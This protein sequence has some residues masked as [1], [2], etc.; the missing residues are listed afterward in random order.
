MALDRDGISTAIAEL[1]RDDSILF[2]PSGFLQ[3]IEGD[4]KKFSNAKVDAKRNRFALY[5][6][7][8]GQDSI[9]IRSQNKDVLFS[10]SMRFEG[11][12]INITAG[13]RNV[14][15]AYERSMLLIDKQMWDGQ[16]LTQYYTDETA[17][18]INMESGGSTLPPPE[19]LDGNLFITEVE[20]AATVEINRWQI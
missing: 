4:P 2:G 16:Y 1:L 5:I 20:G 7:A 17:S 12:D 8:E 11:L 19:E 14:E 6:W 9:S 18:V 15:D 3:I 13:I 10:L